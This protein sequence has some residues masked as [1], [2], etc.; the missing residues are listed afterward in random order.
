MT[1]ILKSRKQNSSHAVAA[2]GRKKAFGRA[3]KLRRIE[4]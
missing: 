2:F 1:F 3:A 4:S